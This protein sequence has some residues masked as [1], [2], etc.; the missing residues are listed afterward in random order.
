MLAKNTIKPAVVSFPLTSLRPL[1]SSQRGE[2]LVVEVDVD[3]MREV[4]E[5]S[6]I[7]EMVAEAR[8]EYALGKSRTFTS[9]D[10]LIRDLHS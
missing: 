6:T 3:S 7:D 2:K 8:L 10:A 1:Y 5:P 9:A 4:N